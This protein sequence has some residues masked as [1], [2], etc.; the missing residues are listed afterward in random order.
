MRVREDQLAAR[1][2]LAQPNPA[3]KARER[4]VPGFTSGHCRRFREPEVS[5]VDHGEAIL[6]VPDHRPLAFAFA[7]VTRD[8]AEHIPGKP[9]LDL[10]V[11]HREHLLEADQ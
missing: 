9:F 10:V 1:R 11:L 3:A 5:M 2:F 7:V 4:S 6:T 8:A